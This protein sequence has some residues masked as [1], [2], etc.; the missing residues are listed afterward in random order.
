V[1]LRSSDFG[2]A[3][4]KTREGSVLSRTPLLCW[5]SGSSARVLASEFKLQYYSKKKKQRKK[6]KDTHIPC[7]FY[8]TEIEVSVGHLFALTCRSRPGPPV[9]L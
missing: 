3:P 8:Q 7:L 2:T 1:L 9:L 4:E 5:W 6:K